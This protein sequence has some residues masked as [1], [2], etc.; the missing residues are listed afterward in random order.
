MM[1][2]DANVI[3]QPAPTARPRRRLTPLAGGAVMLQYHVTA[4][5]HQNLILILQPQLLDRLQELQS[6][7]TR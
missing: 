3:A 2:E 7:T 4:G 5:V 6:W 1:P